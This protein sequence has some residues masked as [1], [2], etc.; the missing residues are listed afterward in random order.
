MAYFKMEL[1][2]GTALKETININKILQDTQLTDRKS[3]V[4]IVIL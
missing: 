3:E 1:S 4:N 2:A